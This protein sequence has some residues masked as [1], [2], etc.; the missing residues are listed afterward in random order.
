MIA[1]CLNCTK[2]WIPYQTRP[3]PGIFVPGSR[4]LFVGQ[5][6]AVMRYEEEKEEYFHA[7]TDEEVMEWYKR[8]FLRSNAYRTIGERYLWP[9]WLEDGSFSFT[10]AVRCRTI[11]NAKP[12]PWVEDNCKRFT[13][14]II[15]TGFDGIIAMGNTA[16]RQ[17]FPKAVFDQVY[18]RKAD[19]L[20]YVAIRHYA[21]RRPIHEQEYTEAVINKF[22]DVTGFR[23]PS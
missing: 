21:A 19:G 16:R 13:D 2:C 7:V 8:W 4:L 17:L 11:D 14:E 12:M 15:A 6:P 18:R 23:H 9:G 22:L 20:H 3:M 10:N 5:N 1:E